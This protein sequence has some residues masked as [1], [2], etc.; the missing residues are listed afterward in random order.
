MR[1]RRQSLLLFISIALYI[2]GLHLIGD[3]DEPTIN[4]QRRYFSKWFAVIAKASNTIQL[5]RALMR[6]LEAL[7]MPS[8]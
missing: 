4:R 8:M 7:I 3:R 1:T 5:L 6:V 2:R